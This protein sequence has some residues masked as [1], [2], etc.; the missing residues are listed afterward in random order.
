MNIN[1]YKNM[2]FFA[3][4]EGGGEGGGGETAPVGGDVE[5][6][7][8]AQAFEPVPK[9]TTGD[10][11]LPGEKPKEKVPGSGP[12]GAETEGATGGEGEGKQV[13]PAAFDP[14]QFAK[15]LGAS[16]TESLKPALTPKEPAQK[17]TPEEAKKFLNVWE[18]DDNWYKLYDNLETRA[19]AVKQMRDGL[20][21]QA[22]TLN[23]LRLQEA[24]SQLRDELAPG[25]KTVQETAEQQRETRLH[26]QYPA[27]ARP[28]Y[29]PLINA[30]TQ[31]FVNQKKT[32]KTE[33][34]LFKAV[35][36]GVEAMM[37]VGNPE[38]KLETVTTNGN[39][40]QQTEGRG[41]RSLPVSTPGGGGGTGR[42]DGGQKPDKPRG[43]AIFDKA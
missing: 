36:N 30:V 11:P 16:L 29:Q 31:D 12:S 23:Q 19:D 8:G 40:N 37:K 42:R 32:F 13:T 27:L 9:T 43:L 35:A 26:T 28:E 33:G 20:V 6:S 24:I 22:D 5:L 3:P 25:L 39:G 38:Y 14:A 7:R 4:D 18:P 1:K 34:E 2:K 17:M 21:L 41:G 15:D 10:K